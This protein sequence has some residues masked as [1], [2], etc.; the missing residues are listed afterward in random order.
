MAEHGKSV[1]TQKAKVDDLKSSL[2]DMKK[3]LKR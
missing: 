3:Q 1:E 2:D